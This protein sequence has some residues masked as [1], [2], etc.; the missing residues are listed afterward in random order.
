ME[1]SLEENYR[2][3]KDE[4][5]EAAARVKRPAHDVLLVA[6]TKY[7]TPDQIRAL[8]ELGHGDLGESRVQQLAQRVPQLE[9]FLDRKRTLAGAAP[10]RELPEQVRWHMIGHLQRNKAKQVVPL[11]CLIHSVDSLRLAE[12]LDTLG[13]RFDQM[14]DI[15]LQVNTSGEQSKYGVA[16]PAA[17]H[18]AE[19]LDTMM[20]IRLR[21]VMAMAPYSDNPEDARPTFAR[22]AEIFHE[23]RSA[24]V[25][26][27]DLTVLSM[28]MSNDFQVAIEEG[29][30]LVRI[31]RGLFGDPYT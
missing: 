12:E 7:A 1:A 2:R 28:G 23:L 26:G 19:Q 10:P 24:K 11:V 15:L 25:G 30:N 21:G 22:A 13:H 8:V 31:G 27:N 3:I 6:V 18:L 14:I 9:E 5:G 20:N 17:V 29:A 4:I 16:A